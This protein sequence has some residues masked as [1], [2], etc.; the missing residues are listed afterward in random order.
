LIGALALLGMLAMLSILSSEMPRMAA[1]PLAL[2][3]LVYGLWR[4]WR[5]S[6]SP[7]RQFHFAGGELPATLDGA[8]I[9]SV[10]VQWRGPLAFVSWRGRDGVHRRL[11]WWPDTLT[12]VRRRELRLASG[13]HEASRNRPAMAP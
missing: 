8:P 12:A 1:W 7:A 5:E 3:A 10:T 9:E 2:S 4:A 13:G 6:R 11:S